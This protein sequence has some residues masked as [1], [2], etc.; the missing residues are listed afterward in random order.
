MIGKN[1]I[2]S[3]ALGLIGKFKYKKWDISRSLL[4]RVKVRSP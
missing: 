2:F 3:M 4:D 1:S